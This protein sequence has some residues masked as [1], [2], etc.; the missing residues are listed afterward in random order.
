MTAGLAR[1]DP[2]SQAF[3]AYQTDPADQ[4]SLPAN[5]IMSLLEDTHG[6]LWVGTYGGGLAR[7]DRARD[8]FRRYASAPAAGGLSSDRATALAEDQSG[9]LWVGTDGGGL[10]LLDPDTGTV[11]RFAHQRDDTGTLSANTV[12]AV[13]VDARGSV[14]VGTRGGGLDHIIGS[15][16]RPERSEE[17]TSE[18]QSRENLVC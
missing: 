13:H 6:N 16:R 3:R 10:N 5:G 11:V 2:G 9:K 18:L 17:H 8:S 4:Q 15:A 12:Y 7:F 1:L 14:W